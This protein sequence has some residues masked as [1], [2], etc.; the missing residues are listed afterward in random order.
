LIFGLDS[1]PSFEQKKEVCE[2][3]QLN[4]FFNQ[5]PLRYE[6]LLEEGGNILSGGQRQ[7]LALAR[8]KLK[9]PDIFN[10]DEATSGLETLLE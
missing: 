7:R 3:V 6:T 1:P 8:A 2:I 10:L 9:N 5:Q 4:E